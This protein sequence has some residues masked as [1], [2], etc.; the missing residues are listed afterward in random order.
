MM[1]EESRA[2]ASNFSL[3][4]WSALLL[5]SALLIAL[6][7]DLSAAIIWLVFTIFL[8]LAALYYRSRLFS[9]NAEELLSR[10]QVASPYDLKRQHSL[11]IILIL[12]TAVAFFVPLFLSAALSSSVWIGSL[13]G[14]IDGWILGLLLYN[15][16]LIRWQRRNDGELFILETWNGN[17]VTHLGLSFVRKGKRN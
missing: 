2:V 11:L 5:L 17:E 1:K 6:T 16:F 8:S 9:K 3:A 15:L 13:I 7:G 4:Y 14:V 12:S 10:G